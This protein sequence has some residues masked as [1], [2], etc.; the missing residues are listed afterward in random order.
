[1]LPGYESSS[2]APPLPLLS[3]SLS[4]LIYNVC[5]FVMLTVSLLLSPSLPLSSYSHF[6]WWVQFKL[7]RGCIRPFVFSYLWECCQCTAVWTKQP[8]QD[9]LEMCICSCNFL[10]TAL[11]GFVNKFVRTLNGQTNFPLVQRKGSKLRGE[12][13]VIGQDSDGFLSAETLLLGLILNLTL[14]VV[15]V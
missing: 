11:G 4:L 13:E 6:T 12:R 14:R 1:M 9:H 7:N 5:L 15:E 8:H 2:C 10:F 3:V